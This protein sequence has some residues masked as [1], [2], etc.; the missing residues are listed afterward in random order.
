MLQ[1]SD[2][3]G[4]KLQSMNS[5][6]YEEEFPPLSRVK[7]RRRTR[8]DIVTCSEQKPNMSQNAGPSQCAA[9]NLISCSEQNPEEVQNNDPLQGEASTPVSDFYDTDLPTSFGKKKKALSSLRNPKFCQTYHEPRQAKTRSKPS[10]S[11]PMDE[12][13][14]ICPPETTES[15][16]PGGSMNMRNS[17]MWSPAD[18]N[19]QT[20]GI[21]EKGKHTEYLFEDSGMVLRPGMVLLK[22][23]IPLL[24]QVV[25]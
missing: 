19:E 16:S 8:I 10:S 4:R 5:S 22:H 24:E 20:N 7:S 17:G 13:F 3:E 15:T 23:Y 9:S 25:V 12:P 1:V 2:K 14:D 11:T 21:E 18:E 6:T